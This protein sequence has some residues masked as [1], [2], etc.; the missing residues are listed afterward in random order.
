MRLHFDEIHDAFVVA[1]ESDRNLHHDGV[2]LELLAQLC[3][4]AKR[5]GAGAV[6]LVDEGE[7]RDFVSAHLPVDGHRLGL[8]PGD[9]AQH[10]DRPVQNPQRPFNLD[11]EVHVAGS[12]DDVDEV[13][14][15]LAVSRGRLD[16]NAALPLEV[17]GVHLRSDA[18]LPLDVVDDAD[19]LRVEK[20]SLGQCCFTR[21][22]VCADS[23]V[24]YPFQIADHYNPHNLGQ[25]FPPPGSYILN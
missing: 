3:G 19:A 23:D 18:V 6:G 9:S 16:R 4:H 1:F 22:D 7:P 11:R 14:V 21:I 12:V 13:V 24:S 5:V 25:T 8:H 2:V 15:P 20:N 17:H 10:Q